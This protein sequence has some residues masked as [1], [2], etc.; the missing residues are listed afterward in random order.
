MI[1][2]IDFQDKKVLIRVDFNVPLNEAL[3]IT[4]DT[5]MRAALPT[6][7]HVLEAGG[8]AIL[9]SH[10]G[11][12][13]NGYQDRFSLSHL[14]SHLQKLTGVA[15]TFANNCIGP[16]TQEIC[17]N[18]SVNEI[19]LL[20]NLRFHKEE[21][22]G[23]QEF[24]KALSTLGEIYINDAF[25]TAHRAHASTAVIAQYFSQSK[26][27]GYLMRQ[28]LENL[29]RV[30][31]NPVHPVTAILGGAK[32]AG[33]IETIKRLMSVVDNIVI[34]GGMSYTFIKAKG[35]AVGNSLVDSEKIPVAKEIIDTAEE[36]NVTLHFPVDSLISQE[37]SN[38]GPVETSDIYNIPDGWIGLD[39]GA[40]SLQRFK[41]VIRGSKTILWN[42]PMG[43]FEMSN[44]QTGSK[45][46]ADAI[47]DATA[48]GAYS[49][50]GGG[51]SVAA[52]N[53]FGLSDQVSYLSTGG[54]ALLEYVEGKSLPGVESILH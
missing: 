11:R 16:E 52:I 10:L 3:E 8:K 44:F 41:E 40:E 36:Q 50:I 43:V 18:S 27:F 25:G 22:Q 33:K 9:M 35:G 7:R 19:V 38:E 21:Q 48:N 12:P 20:E 30:L 39:I 15:V 31:D 53:Q 49:L 32:I 17:A 42:G 46:V 54:G 2:T 14:V 34:G 24:A 28:E 23:D 5:R 29:E 47:A 4:D 26:M 13:E 51:D 1:E 37:F 45:G 6:I